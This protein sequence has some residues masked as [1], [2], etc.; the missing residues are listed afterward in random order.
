MS[1]PK[2]YDIKTDKVEYLA[3]LGCT[4][5]EIAGFYGCDESLIRHSYSVF[6]TKGR[7]L[8]KIRLRQLQW[9]AGEAGN[10]AMLIW[11]GKNILGQVDKTHTIEETVAVEDGSKKVLLKKLIEHIDADNI[12]DVDP[13]P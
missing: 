7:Q 9:R 12:I 11:L 4:N 1:R 10:I 13:V 2:E 8:L 3:K 6:L 5:K